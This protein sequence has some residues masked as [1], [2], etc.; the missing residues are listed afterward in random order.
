MDDIIE[1]RAQE[2]KD[3]QEHFRLQAQ[4]KEKEKDVAPI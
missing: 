3:I 2:A 4:E 1:K